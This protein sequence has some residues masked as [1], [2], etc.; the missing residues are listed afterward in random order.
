M[1]Q[2]NLLPDVKMQYI[3]AQR[4]RNMVLSTAVIISLASVALLV[5]LLVEVARRARD[6]EVRH[7]DTVLRVPKFGIRSDVSYHSDY[8][9]ASHLLTLLP[10]RHCER[11]FECRRDKFACGFDSADCPVVRPSDAGVHQE[12]RNLLPTRRPSARHRARY[13]PSDFLIASAAAS[14]R[15]GGTA[16]PICRKRDDCGPFQSIPSGKVWIAAASS[17]VRRRR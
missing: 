10:V 11:F 17:T 7:R 6:G 5:L 8:G 2:L 3:K 14:A 4:T 1:I 16:F 12:R 9:F 13:S 15:R